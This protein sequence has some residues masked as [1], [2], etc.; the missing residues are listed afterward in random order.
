MEKIK[1]GIIGLD[2]T[3]LWYV[4]TI[5]QFVPDAELIAASSKNLEELELVETDYGI[6]QNYVDFRDMISLHELDGVI[7]A[8]NPL[9]RVRQALESLD[10]GLHVLLVTPIAFNVT[11]SE[12]LIKKAAR[13]P[14][15]LVMAAMFKRFL[16]IVQEAKTAIKAG[17]IGDI[18]SILTDSKFI[19]QKSTQ[20]ERNTSE[21]GSAFMDFGIQDIDIIR[22]LTGHEFLQAYALSQ[23]ITADRKSDPADFEIVRASGKLSGDIVFDTQI[24]IAESGSHY[25]QIKVKG[26]KGVLRLEDP[27]WKLYRENQKGIEI[28]GSQSFHAQYQTA[29]T[30]QIK[31]FCE[32]VRNSGKSPVRIED[33]REA[34][35]V[36]VALSKSLALNELIE[37]S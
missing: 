16:P 33:A 18:V 35:K 8:S 14:N 4:N 22:Y 2:S 25:Y 13:Y 29:L 31:V 6:K 7:I 9:Q 11:D 28:L 21:S 20:E 37:I 36:S 1:L 15:Q 26:T 5:Q 23:S 30:Q 19:R 27:G 17:E 24:T 34:I 10:K 12:K 3:S 32:A